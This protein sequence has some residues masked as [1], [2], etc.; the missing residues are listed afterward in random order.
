M[1]FGGNTPSALAKTQADIVA[2]SIE[3]KPDLLDEDMSLPGLPQIHLMSESQLMGFFETV[4]KTRP[5]IRKIELTLGKDYNTTERQVAIPN[6]DKLHSLS[7]KD[8]ARVLTMSLAAGGE[9][10]LGF[11]AVISTNE[12]QEVSSKLYIKTADK[13]VVGHTYDEKG[14]IVEYGDEEFNPQLIVTCKP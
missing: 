1:G 8:V 12:Q 13:P 7:F 14:E 2:E 6:S 9:A 11:K 5:L 3:A 4:L 10:C